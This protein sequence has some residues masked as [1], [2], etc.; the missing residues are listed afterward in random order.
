MLNIKFAPEQREAV[1]TA[2]TNGISIVTGGPGTG[3]TLIQRAILDIY[4]RNYPKNVICCYAPTGRAA[5]RMT[6]L[7]GRD[8][9]TVHRLLGAI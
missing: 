9:A 8:A 3:K 2:L 1:K 4:S 7:T 6:E 5:K